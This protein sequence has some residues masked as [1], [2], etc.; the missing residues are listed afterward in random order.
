M[1]ASA[2]WFPLELSQ[3]LH[4]LYARTG[5]FPP[6]INTY[7]E[8]KG[9][10]N[11]ALNEPTLYPEL[12]VPIDKDGDW[13]D[14]ARGVVHLISSIDGVPALCVMSE[15]E[16]DKL[17]T[18]EINSYF[19]HL[20]CSIKQIKPLPLATDSILVA[21]NQYIV[22]HDNFL[23][24]RG[25]FLV[26]QILR[27]RIDGNKY[28]DESYELMAGA[29]PSVVE[30]G[31]LLF[32]KILTRDIGNPAGRSLAIV[33]VLK[34]LE[35][36]LGRFYFEEYKFARGS[37]QQHSLEY[38]IDIDKLKKDCFFFAGSPYGDIKFQLPFSLAVLEGVYQYDNSLLLIK[39]R[40]VVNPRAS[41]VA[42]GNTRI[43]PMLASHGLYAQTEIEILVKGYID[44]DFKSPPQ[45]EMHKN[46][47]MFPSSIM[48]VSNVV[49]GFIRSI[50]WANNRCD[51]PEIVPYDFNN[52][53]FKQYDD[54]GNVVNDVPFLSLEFVRV[55]VGVPAVEKEMI[56]SLFNVDNLSYEKE[57]LISAKRF[58]LANNLRRAVLDFSGAFES[59]VYKYIQPKLSKSSETTKDKF[60]KLYGRV[61]PADCV[62]HIQRASCDEERDIPFVIFKIIKE[63]EK[64][65]TLPLI[66]KGAKTSIS[67]V[68]PSIR[69]LAAHGKPVDPKYIPEMV[70]AIDGLEKLIIDFEG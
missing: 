35:F 25:L 40:P 34:E 36:D 39:H 63:Y 49:N 18:N 5:G 22:D 31:Q 24:S 47:F 66:D 11:S 6:I 4:E 67:K 56:K 58:L 64:G 38:Y 55:D 10:G 70:D 12:N 57:L 30:K 15:L 41:F 1:A 32:N 68:F 33:D 21:V 44:I 59:F 50:Y 37:K 52:I 48:E 42:G 13:G 46:V 17:I 43:L 3:L 9:Y 20:Y 29:F 2:V 69:N 16:N 60:L 7:S 45:N 8:K 51:V 62:E 27:L 28:A 19:N 65:K 61:L 23:P 26:L 54:R 53:S 14:V